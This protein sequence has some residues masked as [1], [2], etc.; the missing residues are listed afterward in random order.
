MTLPGR[1]WRQATAPGNPIIAA[2][3][4]RGI[5]TRGQFLSS[6]LKTRVC[7][8]SKIRNRESTSQPLLCPVRVHPGI[9]EI[10]VSSSF[11]QR[12]PLSLPKVCSGSRM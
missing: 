6:W 4:L 3:D 5:L 7:S 9:L 10:S 12:L 11:H 2:P 8:K 1:P